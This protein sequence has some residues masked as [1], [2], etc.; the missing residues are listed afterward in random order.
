MKN[1]EPTR[2]PAADTRR[3]YRVQARRQSEGTIHWMANQVK[4]GPAAASVPKDSTVVRPAVPRW[5][6]RQS[7]VAI[8]A[9][10]VPVSRK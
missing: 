4:R 7:F 5:E 3:Y 10:S 9:G 8:K 2:E 1:P 6:E